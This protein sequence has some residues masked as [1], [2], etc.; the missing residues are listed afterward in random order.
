MNR[1]L[2]GLA[3]IFTLVFASHVVANAQQKGVVK[4]STAPDA[5]CNISV[6]RQNSLVA[7]NDV[8]GEYLMATVRIRNTASADCEYEYTITSNGLT[9]VQPFHPSFNCVYQE[10]LSAKCTGVIGQGVTATAD[11]ITTRAKME[12]LN[13][14]AQMSDQIFDRTPYFWTFWIAQLHIPIVAR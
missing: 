6:V 5:A 4:A 13:G 1:L 9:S 8:P 2:T 14:Y 10:P 11:F 3:L 7:T 12:S